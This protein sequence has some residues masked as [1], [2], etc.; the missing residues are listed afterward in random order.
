MEF[1]KSFRRRSVL[2]ELVYI[3]LNVGLAIAVLIIVRTVESP[4]PAFILVLI[5]KWRVFAVRPRYWLANIQA[6]FVDFI[7]SISTVVLLYGVGTIGSQGLLL[8]IALT[9]LYVA[10]L[11]YLKPRSSKR[12]VVAQAWT[13]VIVGTTAL[14]IS[15]YNWPIEL[16]IMGL[17]VVGYVAAR[18]AL[19][20][21]EEDHLQ[22][23]SLLN[24]L[25]MA[26][27]GWV[28]YHWVIAY[29]L[30]VIDIRIPQATLII[31]V[32]SFV[33]FKIYDSYKRNDR[34]EPADVALPIL[35][36][37]SIISV[38]LLFFSAIPIGVL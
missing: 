20:Q 29:S 28:L 10:W 2:S 12:S 34:I 30:P 9:I 17:A 4:L 14:F 19:T 8:Q 16:L 36:G 26:Q 37:V 24:A 35:F 3:G 21:Y 23:L 27:L 1:L 11:I 18:H 15:S 6:N 5:S 25:I 32:T 31:A 38:L 22:F 33:L 7:V 13:A